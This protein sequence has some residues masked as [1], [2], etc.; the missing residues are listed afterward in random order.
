MLT[1]MTDNVEY[2]QKFLVEHI[3]MSFWGEL[4]DLPF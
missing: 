1:Q 2:F 3:Q 4:I